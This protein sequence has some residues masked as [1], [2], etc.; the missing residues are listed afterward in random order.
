MPGQPTPAGHMTA[1]DPP[2]RWTRYAHESDLA[3]GED[4]GLSLN[5]RPVPTG[6]KRAPPYTSLSL[7]LTRF[8]TSL[9]ACV[10]NENEQIRTSVGKDLFKRRR[11]SAG[12]ATAA[13]WP[14]DDL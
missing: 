5:V 7:V 10:P 6:P 8:G 14:R 3:W 9:S 2:G 13:V 12:S 11:L 4:A 1:L